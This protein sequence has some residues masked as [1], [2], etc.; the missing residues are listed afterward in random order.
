MVNGALSLGVIGIQGAV[1]EHVTMVKQVF[2]SCSVDGTVQIIKP[3][4]SLTGID[5][6]ILPG[7]ESTTISRVLQSSGLFAELQQRALKGSI[8]V[9]GTCAGC[10]LLARK[11]INDVQDIELL[12]LMSM[13]V[14]RNAYGRQKESFEQRI[15]ISSLHSSDT[16]LFPAV[17]IRAP[18]INRIWGENAEVLAVDSS[19]NPVMVHE[20]NLLALTFHPELSHDDRIHHYFISLVENVKKQKK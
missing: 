6:V 3:S 16:S 2:S 19:G 8:A 9:M 7:G 13:E 20:N 18:L 15:D 10:I 5:G 14:Q 11:V 4:G 1:S 12:K 17:F